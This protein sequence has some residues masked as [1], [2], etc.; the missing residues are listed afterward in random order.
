M[1][2]VAAHGELA[3]LSDDEL[4]SLLPPDLKVQGCDWLSELTLAPLL[5]AACCSL[6][7][8]LDDAATIDDLRGAAAHFKSLWEMEVIDPAQVGVEAAEIF[9]DVEEA[10]LAH[11]MQVGDGINNGI[12]RDRSFSQ[13][14][15]N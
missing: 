5:V 11:A 7:G 9:R 6:S 12:A 8:Q 4:K 13:A 15:L 3:R 10:M 14:E 1:D 2:A